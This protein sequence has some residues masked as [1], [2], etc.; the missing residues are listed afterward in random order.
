MNFLFMGLGLILIGVRAGGEGEVACSSPSYRNYVTSGK[1]P[2][3]FRQRHLRENCMK[4]SVLFDK[5]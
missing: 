3:L 5:I 4:Y 1:T 2:N